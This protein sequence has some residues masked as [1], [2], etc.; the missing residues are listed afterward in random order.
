MRIQSLNHRIWGDSASAQAGVPAGAGGARPSVH[1]GQG[2]ETSAQHS[3]VFCRE[4]AREKHI[5][6][7]RG[8]KALLS[9]G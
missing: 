4:Q 9:T 8:Q 5:K 6:E 7:S 3:Q 2:Q 1:T